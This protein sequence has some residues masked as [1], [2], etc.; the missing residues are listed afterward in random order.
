[1]RL[2]KTSS[3]LGETV[4]RAVYAKRVNSSADGFVKMLKEAGIEKI[5]KK[6]FCALVLAAFESL[7]E[8]T[9]GQKA[10]SNAWE[11]LLERLRV[12]LES[13]MQSMPGAHLS[14]FDARNT[15][16][17]LAQQIAADAAQRG[18]PIRLPDWPLK[19]KTGPV[20]QAVS[21]ILDDIQAGQ[22]VGGGTG[23]VV[24]PQQKAQEE[25]AKKEL[26]KPGIGQLRPIPKKPQPPPAQ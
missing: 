10:Q 6:D 23:K 20:P 22:E 12:A 5:S 21:K 25:L 4:T 11:G 16:V 8:P 18:M 14:L 9:P 7:A 2:T 13:Q 24:T 19:D 26:Q 1:M 3:L 17:A 15:Y